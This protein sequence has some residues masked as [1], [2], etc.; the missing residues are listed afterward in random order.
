MSTVKLSRWASR[1]VQE[2]ERLLFDE[3]EQGGREKQ[4]GGGQCR[5]GVVAV[6]LRLSM[7][8]KHLSSYLSEVRKRGVEEQRNRRLVPLFSLRLA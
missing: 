2:E 1:D 4:G 8:Y 3:E 5:R 6:V 7:L